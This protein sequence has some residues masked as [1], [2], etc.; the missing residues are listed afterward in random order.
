MA[1]GSCKT[2]SGRN[3]RSQS[4]AGHFELR[5]EFDPQALSLTTV[6][7]LDT[8]VLGIVTHPK[9]DKPEV[10]NCIKWLYGM[11]EAG[12]RIC[13]PE[14]CDYELRRAYILNKSNIPLER[15]ESLIS[16]LTYVPVDTSMM[17]RAAE[18]WA[19]ARSRG[20]QTAD[21]KELDCDVVL[22]AQAL[23]ST[24][25]TESAVVATTNVGHL[26]LFLRADTWENIKPD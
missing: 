8:G 22:A 25:Q 1:R 7:Y 5:E 18:L 26:S 16:V 4:N 14:I 20:K 2:D 11:L 6:V 17:R 13:V 19:D 15:L 24:A 10:Q 3:Q 9:A 21:E 23:V 12:A